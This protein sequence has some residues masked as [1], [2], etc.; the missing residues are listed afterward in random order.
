MNVSVRR[1]LSQTPQESAVSV[2]KIEL[3]S[4]NR[5]TDSCGHFCTDNRIGDCYLSSEGAENAPICT[6]PIG[7]VT[8][9]RCCCSKARGW[10]NP[11]EV[12]PLPKT[13][14]VSAKLL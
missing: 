9:S 6:N 10:G 12:C 14:E 7:A 4:A 2:R 3:G 1:D 8:K 13:P 11:C 5:R